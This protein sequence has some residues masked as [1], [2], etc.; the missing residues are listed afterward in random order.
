M[1]LAELKERVINLL[2]ESDYTYFTET[3]IE[4]W[5]NEGQYQIANKAK[6]LKE[7][8]YVT[9]TEDVQTYELPDDYIDHFRITYGDDEEEKLDKVE[10]GSDTTGYW[11]WK[12]EINLTFN[13]DG[14]NLNIYY[15]YKP[16]PMENDTEE[17][18]VPEEFQN[19]L[20][21]Y[22]LYKAFKKQ[23][24]TGDTN[25]FDVSNYYKREFLEGIQEM[26]SRYSKRPSSKQWEVKRL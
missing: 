6:H 18:E 13:P 7:S 9:T 19:L 11:I 8:A 4:D 2:S 3:E 14:E 5:L 22:A 23:G 17:P 10:M 26:Q 21:H 16:L 20:V 15:Y 25:Y 24:A 1:T 12:D